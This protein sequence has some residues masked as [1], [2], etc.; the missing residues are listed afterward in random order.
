VR[1]AIA[2]AAVLALAATAVADQAKAPAGSAAAGAP[3]PHAAA[4][5][6]PMPPK[7][8]PAPMPEM[9]PAQEVTDAAKVMVGS[10]KCKGVDFNP[11]GSS[12][13]SLL[14]MK[15]STELGG[16]YI[17]V[18]LQEQKSKDN[19]TPFVAKMYRTFDAGSKKWI[20]TII[21]SAP[22]GPMTM[23]TTDTMGGQVTWTGTASMMGQT[24]TE[25]SHEEP[26]AK[27]KSVHLWGEVSLDGG[28]TFAKEYDVTCKK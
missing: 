12:R 22:G 27:T 15:I 8:P 24:F 2:I 11:D 10:Y 28:K 6:A 25:K 26:D 7:Q 19:P 20:D 9:K 18:D 14:T 4:V 21:A 3:A 16:Y 13:P 17:L 23:N 1:G 5:V